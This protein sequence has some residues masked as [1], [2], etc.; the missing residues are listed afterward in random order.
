MN[1]KN[2]VYQ[3]FN[4]SSS[5]STTTNGRRKQNIHIS[6]KPNKTTILFYMLFCVFF[7]FLTF[8]S[9]LS[10]DNLSPKYYKIPISIILCI[11]C[12]MI[13]WIKS[14]FVFHKL[15]HKTTNINIYQRDLPS[16]LRAAH[17][18]MLLNDGLIDDSSLASTLL[19]LVDRGYLELKRISSSSSSSK[20]DIFHNDEILLIQTEKPI[21]NLFQYEQYLINWFIHSY[22]DGK[23]VSTKQIHNHLLGKVHDTLKPCEMFEYWQ[24]LVLISFPL[25]K[26]FT[27]HDSTKSRIT[28][29]IFT[30]LGFLPILGFIGQILA[31]Y[32]L[33][34]LMFATPLYVLNQTGVDEKD[35]WLDLKKYLLD[36]SDMKSK[37]LEMVSLWEFYLTYSIALGIPSI[38]NK[39]IENFFGND[40]F[41]YD[42]KASSKNSDYYAKVDTTYHNQTIA[43]LEKDILEEAKKYE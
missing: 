37:T 30:L 12:F 38:A 5:V 39:E 41:N 11:I 16:N 24:A 43:Q 27:S 23:Q 18:R 33:G 34:C 25:K 32:G 31:I 21:E 1:Y 9:E 42:K 8:A 6:G 35:A 15:E 4:F 26:F 22:G 7:T 40:I 29:A 2:A 13:V 14:K 19:D 36:F 17:V 3:Y 20:I 10:T 28:Y